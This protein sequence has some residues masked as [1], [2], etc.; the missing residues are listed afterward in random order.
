[1]LDPIEPPA[2]P[3]STGISTFAEALRT[4]VESSGLGLKSIQRRMRE[5]GSAISVATLSYWQSGRS[6]PG[7]RES[8]EALEHLEHVLDLPAGALARL[9]P[10]RSDTPPGE[11]INTLA[12]AIGEGVQLPQIFTELD[13]RLRRTVSLFSE[14]V[15]MTV[16]AD[17][18]QHTG[19]NRRIVRAVASGV[20]RIILAHQVSDPE[21]ALPTVRPL[22]HCTVGA[23]HVVTPQAVVLTELLFDRVLEKGESVVVEYD[24]DYGP[25]F[26]VDSFHELKRQLPLRE[27][28][29]E[30]RFDPGA[31][32]T[33][34]EWY[35]SS[36]QE[37]DVV[38]RTTPVKIN[39]TNSVLVVRHDLPPMRYGLRWFWD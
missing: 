27:F 2:D 9:V 7:R 28:V 12:A 25:P 33:R 13:A 14:H 29:M 19:W 16:G 3:V 30:V 1:M 11:S 26:P 24:V 6:M 8:F 36:R 31:R 10:Q 4:A 22:T 20:N 5:R 15:L 23:R 39:T 21:A 38:R 17:R 35:Q 18:R 37:P 34:C 32:P